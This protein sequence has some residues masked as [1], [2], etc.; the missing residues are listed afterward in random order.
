M[1]SSCFCPDGG[2]VE[3]NKDFVHGDRWPWP[4]PWVKISPPPSEHATGTVRGIRMVW[5]FGGSTHPMRTSCTHISKTEDRVLICKQGDTSLTERGI[6]ALV[7]VNSGKIFSTCHLIERKVL[8]MPFVPSFFNYLWY[9]MPPGLGVE[10]VRCLAIS[11][12]SRY[13]LSPINCFPQ[14]YPDSI[15]CVNKIISAWF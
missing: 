14:E 1:V 11:I 6:W 8:T 15:S 9:F 3:L 7:E 13:F 5:E 12:E 4:D 2:S 10:G